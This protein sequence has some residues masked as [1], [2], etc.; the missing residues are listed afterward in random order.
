MGNYEVA[1]KHFKR[2]SIVSAGADCFLGVTE[3][4]LMQ[5]R[6]NEARQWMVKYQNYPL[7]LDEKDEYDEQMVILREKITMEG[8]V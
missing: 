5:G 6:T 7:P 3:C 4:L 8:K 1:E 2:A